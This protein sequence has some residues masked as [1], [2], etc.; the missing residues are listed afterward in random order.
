MPTLTIANLL[1]DQRLLELARREA[2]A[3]KSDS[4]DEITQLEVG[5]ALAEL[6][7]RWRRTYGLVEAG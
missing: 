2:Q 3:A 7:V 5:R 4:K 1:R 6:R